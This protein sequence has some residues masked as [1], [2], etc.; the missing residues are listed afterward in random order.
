MLHELYCFDWNITE[1]KI[2]QQQNLNHE[3][4]QRMWWSNSDEIFSS[5]KNL[6]EALNSTHKILSDSVLGKLFLT[7]RR[8]VK[9]VSKLIL[10]WIAPKFAEKISTWGEDGR[11]PWSF[12]LFHENFI[13]K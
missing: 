8:L 6:G 5:W 1:K 12:A 2:Q 10:V 13:T 7:T 4:L 9:I 11:E 3:E